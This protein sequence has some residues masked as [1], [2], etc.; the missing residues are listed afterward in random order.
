[1]IFFDFDG[2]VVDLW[3]RY[4][5]V[6][7][8]ASGLSGVSLPDYREAKRA[9][10][11][12]RAVARRFGTELP[13]AYFRRKRALLESED[14]LCLDRLL[15]APE[16]LEAFF[17]QASCRILTSRRRAGAFFKE[18]EFL[19]LG[20]LAGR[21]IVLDPGRGVSK[22][23]FLAREFPRG[24]H[25]IVGD[26]EAEREAAGLENVRAVLVQ[27]GLRRPEDFPPARR[28]T[29]LPSIR[30][31]LAIYRKRGNEPCQ[32]KKN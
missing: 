20:G 26:S 15:A 22:K 21:S 13:E 9:L 18:L 2:T 29:I 31:F 27:T 16:E 14:L 24:S 19:G 1:M 5:Q 32:S 10:V 11:S 28:C 25:L 3:P 30:E 12:D 23:A 17:S 6:F 8:A 7:L 4:Y